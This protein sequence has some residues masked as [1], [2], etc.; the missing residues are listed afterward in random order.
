M[1]QETYKKQLLDLL[2]EIL[3]WTKFIGKQ[4]LKKLLL[5]T[6]EEG[7]EKVIYELS[8]GKSLKEIEAICKG[9]GYS[10]AYTTIRNYW[11]KW[12]PIGIVE[13]SER[14]KGRYKR[15]VSLEEVGIDFPEIKLKKKVET[16]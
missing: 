9:N 3:K 6:L 2:S 1:T 7:M 12:A 5:D 8:D 16:S 14:F 15:I 4:R 10:V 13:P 11:K